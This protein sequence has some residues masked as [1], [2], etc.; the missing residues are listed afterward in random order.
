MQQETCN[1]RCMLNKHKQF[2]VDPSSYHSKQ[3]L[4]WTTEN[5]QSSGKQQFNRMTYIRLSH[6]RSPFSM[7]RW[8]NVNN[9]YHLWR[10]ACV[11]D[12]KVR[13]SKIMTCI[14][15]YGSKCARKQPGKQDSC[16]S[17]REWYAYYLLHGASMPQNAE[18]YEK[19]EINYARRELNCIFLRRK[20]A[21]LSN[22][23]GWTGFCRW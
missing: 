21:K 8:L 4:R 22:V 17:R 1:S 2:H 18:K 19:H 16:G 12:Q 10:W 20:C 11:C 14:Y 5:I 7:H 6:N 3:L 9:T 23:C 15:G 13:H